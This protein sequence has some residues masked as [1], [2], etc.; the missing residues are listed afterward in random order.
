MKNHRLRSRY[1]FE[2]YTRYPF[3]RYRWYP[4]DR[5]NRYLFE[6]YERYPFSDIFSRGQSTLNAHIGTPDCSKLYAHPVLARGICLR[7]PF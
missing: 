4:F 7:P 2:R 6:R 5:Y 3:E 1:P